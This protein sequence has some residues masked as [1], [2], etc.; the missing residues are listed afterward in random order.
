MT[1]TL[2]RAPGFMSGTGQ[3]GDYAPVSF[4]PLHRE[5]DTTP[6]LTTVTVSVQVTAEDI[7][8]GL[9]WLF[10]PALLESDL[11]A[12]ETDPA[13][14]HQMVSESLWAL[15]GTQLS[16]TRMAMLTTED[17][18]TQLVVA[19]L[20]RLVHRLYGTTVPA[21]RTERA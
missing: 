2:N 4:T 7:A 11:V 10:S 14:A 17:I 8:A 21:P 19:R 12:L 3:V 15:G 9:W 5:G 13:F 20:L 18:D 6:T 1:A 16:E